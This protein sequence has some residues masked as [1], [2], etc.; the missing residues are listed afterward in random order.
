MADL[1]NFGLRF[2][3]GNGVWVWFGVVRDKKSPE[4]GRI[5]YPAVMFAPKLAPRVVPA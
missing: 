1:V 5:S 3:V 2:T 4:P